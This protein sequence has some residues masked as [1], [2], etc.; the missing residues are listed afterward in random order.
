[1]S[2]VKQVLG[3]DQVVRVKWVDD[4]FCLLSKVNHQLEGQRQFFFLPSVMWPEKS[5]KSITWSW[6][7]FKLYGLTLHFKF[8]PHA[9]S[10]RTQLLIIEQIYLQIF[11]TKHLF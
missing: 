10:K 3:L 5:L 4:E 1:M 9:S 2:F 7:V 11:P 6:S 8:E